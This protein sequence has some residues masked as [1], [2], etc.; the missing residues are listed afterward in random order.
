MQLP[1]A[2]DRTVDRLG[3]A[4]TALSRA[5]RN[6]GRRALERARPQLPTRELVRLIGEEEH[7]LSELALL[8]GVG[9]SVVSRQIGELEQ[10]GLVE[11]RTDPSDGRASLLRLTVAG[12]DALADAHRLRRE[13]LRAALA[14]HPVPDVADAAHLIAVLAEELTEHLARD[15]AGTRRPP[16]PGR[17]DPAP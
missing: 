7:R 1:A 2:D 11:R 9:R 4:V 13:W 10:R 12:L 16:V 17:P 5:Y 14:R 6:A 3:D 8:R 15:A